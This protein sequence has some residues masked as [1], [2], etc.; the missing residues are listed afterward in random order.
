MRVKIL[1]TILVLTATR[2]F[3]QQGFPCSGLLIGLP[4]S[5]RFE[6]GI[7]G[8]YGAYSNG[9][10]NRFAGKLYFGGYIDSA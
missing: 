3:A 2:Y 4:D 10:D 7:T 9:F 6:A 8:N 5:S 1:T